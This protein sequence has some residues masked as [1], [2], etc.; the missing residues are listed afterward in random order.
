MTDYECLLDAVVKHD[1]QFGALPDEPHQAFL[2]RLA[3]MIGNSTVVPEEVWKALPKT[4]Q[5]WYD[6]TLEPSGTGLLETLQF[7]EG[8]PPAPPPPPPVVRRRPI[9]VEPPPRLPVFEEV[10]GLLPADFESRKPTETDQAHLK[11]VLDKL[12][13]AIPDTTSEQL[14]A[15]I[16]LADEARGQS[17]AVPLPEGYPSFTPAEA[18]PAPV[19]AA[20]AGNGQQHQFLDENGVPLTG[21]KKYNAELAAGLVT[22]R[23]PEKTKK[24]EKST[25]TT[26]R[27]EAATP[28]TGRRR[29]RTRE[30]TA[31]FLIRDAVIDDPAISTDALQERLKVAGRETTVP[32]IDT[33]KAFVLQ[34]IRLLLHKGWQPPEAMAAK[35]EG[36]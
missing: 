29:G 10:L 20:A 15:W 17:I 25:R 1:P 8:F 5:L 12:P 14:R 4:A 7:P 2:H 34:M 16:T 26:T 19:P 9:V 21:I 30:D 35:L 28:R 24:A 32:T 27:K 13:D 36:V 11:R 33:T 18:P 6:A 31:T 3:D 22:R 23:R